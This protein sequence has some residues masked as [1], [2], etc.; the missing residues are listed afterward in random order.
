M[1]EINFFTAL[2]RQSNKCYINHNTYTALSEKERV[3]VSREIKGN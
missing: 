2:A 3:K 1:H